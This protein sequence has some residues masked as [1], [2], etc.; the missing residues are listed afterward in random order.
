MMKIG[1]EHEKVNWIELSRQK[2]RTGLCG[3][4]IHIYIAT[5]SLYS[6]PERVNIQTFL[7]ILF[8]KWSS[9]EFWSYLLKRILKI[10]LY[11][12]LNVCIKFFFE[13]E[14]WIMKWS[15]LFLFEF[16]V[17]IHTEVYVCCEYGVSTNK[18]VSAFDPHGTSWYWS[19]AFVL[20]S[21]NLSDLA[22]CPPSWS[23]WLWP[24]L[25]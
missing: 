19:V 9:I 6:L 15:K 24:L 7:Y 14:I 22:V 8:L 17:S 10:L 5:I 21:L 1:N 20:C 12:I 25:L 23:P 3:E 18:W 2:P 11:I 4:M 16:I 13:F